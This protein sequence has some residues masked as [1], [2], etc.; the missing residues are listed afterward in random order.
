MAFTKLL[1]IVVVLGLVSF[2]LI[3]SLN[4]DA[5]VAS[6]NIKKFKNNPKELDKNAISKLSIDALPAV[7]GSDIVIRY[8]E[9][10]KKRNCHTFAEYHY[11]YCSTLAKYGES[12]YQKH[13]YNYESGFYEEV[14]E[15]GERNESK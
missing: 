6:H 1:D 4:V 13:I 2:T 10:A 11:G 14:K 7:Q 3:A 8:Y 5:M 15:N 12:H 9:Y